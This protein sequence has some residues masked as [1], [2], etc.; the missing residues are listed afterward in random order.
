MAESIVAD[1][2]FSLVPRGPR[3]VRTVNGDDTV[4]LIHDRVR[5]AGEA[6]AVA[7]EAQDER[8]DRLRELTTCLMDA[9]TFARGGNTH[10]AE[11]AKVVA[12]G[13][14]LMKEFLAGVD[15]GIGVV[16]DHE[17]SSAGRGGLV[18]DLI[19][20]RTLPRHVEQELANR[21]V[22][23]VTRFA[24]VDRPPMSVFKECGG[25]G[26]LVATIGADVVMLAPD[27]DDSRSTRLLG[28]LGGM[29]AGTA[30]TATASRD[31]A[32]IP[33]AYQ[34]A[35]EVLGLVRAGSRDL[36]VYRMADVLVEYAVA[37][38]EGVAGSLAA[39]FRPLMAHE[40][41]RD[42]LDALIRADYNRNRAAKTLFIHRS[43]LDYR[44]Q[45]IERV[46]GYDPA[47]GRGA[48]VLAMAMTA[49]SLSSRSAC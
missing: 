13:G 6:W 29:L 28:E 10:P 19:A 23:A 27:H 38:H 5:A 40:V 25:P 17:D 21:Y 31:R 18:E 3:L 8:A 4:R 39:I 2:V 44:M 49:Y 16:D 43:T 48:Q 37:K 33:E 36:G 1:G 20:D 42:T 30:W 12:A 47:S 46:T 34:E 15:R 11:L 14:E 32:D 45:R 41:L 9:V 35:V 7:G 22:V 24:D 26:T